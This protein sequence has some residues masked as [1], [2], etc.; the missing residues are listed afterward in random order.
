MAGGG[1]KVVIQ[2]I[3]GNAFITGIKT[4]GFMVSGSP[5]LMAEAVHSFADTLNQILL[6]IGLKQSQKEKTQEYSTGTG[7]ARYVWNLVSAVGIFFLGFGVTFYHGMHALFSE[8]VASELSLL[9][10]GILIVSLIIEAWVFVQAYKEVNLIRGKMSFLQYFKESDDPTII[11]V[12][13][14]DGVAV[15]GVCLALIGITLGHVFGSVLFDIAASLLIAT[16][17]AFMAVALG[18]INGKLLL[19][20]SLTVARE[21]EIKKYI[22]ELP[23]VEEISVFSTKIMGAGQI[24]LSINVELHGELVID[25]TSFQNDL[26]AFKQGE[27]AER[28]LTKSNTR[29]VRLTGRMINKLEARIQEQFPEIDIIDFEIT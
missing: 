27:Q 7:S 24:R 29:M 15:I 20:K 28:V 25:K 6:L 23:E 2:A 11:A 19:G 9:G 26:E 12:L 14:E 3:T 8:H 10:I 1:A 17:M 5:S 21:K 13:L 22:Q 4:V 18:I 16:L